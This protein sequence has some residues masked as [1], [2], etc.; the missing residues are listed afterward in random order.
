[1][2][3]NDVIFIYTRYGNPTIAMFEDKIAAIEGA[4]AAFSNCIWNGR[5][6]MEH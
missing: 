1:M 6:V 5:G 3:Q 2:C 4:E